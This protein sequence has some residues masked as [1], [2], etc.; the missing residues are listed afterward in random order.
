MQ[1]CN[2][3]H[4]NFTWVAQNFDKDK[5]IINI[6]G[7]LQKSGKANTVIITDTD[8]IT[9]DKIKNDEICNE[10]INTFLLLEKELEINN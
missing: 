4:S 10:I 5:S 6:A 7:Q 3:K 9:K 2:D 8:Y 1:L